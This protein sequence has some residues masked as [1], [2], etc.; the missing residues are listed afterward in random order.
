MILHRESQVSP[1]NRNMRFGCRRTPAPLRILRDAADVLRIGLVTLVF[2]FLS[3]RFLIAGRMPESL[4]QACAAGVH[5]AE[6][7]PIPVHGTANADEMEV[8]RLQTTDSHLL[9]Q[10]FL[11]LLANAPC[12]LREEAR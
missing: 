6:V 9:H 7:F 3:R 4:Q 11:Q 2:A 10:R 8:R 12:S 1:Q 5:A